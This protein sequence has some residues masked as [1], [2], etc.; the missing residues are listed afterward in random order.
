MAY[1]LENMAAHGAST[2]KPSSASDV[3]SHPDAADA[4]A[5]I[6][7]EALPERAEEAQAAQTTFKSV[8]EYANSYSGDGAIAETV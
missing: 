8:A 2:P 6:V 1:H 3:L 5:L 4:V 7:V